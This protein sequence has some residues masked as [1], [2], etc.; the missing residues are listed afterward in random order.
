MNFE[1]PKFAPKDNLFIIDIGSKEVDIPCSTCD[2]EGDVFSVRHTKTTCPACKGKKTVKGE[3]D[4]G[5]VYR[6]YGR[7]TKVVTTWNEKHCITKY[8]VS[9]T[10]GT[11]TAVSNLFLYTNN[12]EEA[13]RRCEQLNKEIVK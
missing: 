11:A 7:V 8:H 13:K 4:I 5:W 12:E 1:Q 6:P 3:K 10:S 9:L 2:G